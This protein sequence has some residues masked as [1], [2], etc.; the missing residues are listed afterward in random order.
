MTTHIKTVGYPT[1]KRINPK[2][3][4]AVFGASLILFPTLGSAD[5]SALSPDN[6]EINIIQADPLE[7]ATGAKSP[8]VDGLIEYSPLPLGEADIEAKILADQAMDEAVSLLSDSPPSLSTAPSA[9]AISIGKNFA[10]QTPANSAPPDTTGAIGPF[11]F[12]QL[13][14]TKAG[15]FNRTTGALV[16]SGTLNQLANIA[17]TVNSFDPQIIWDPTT[18][19]YYYVMDSIHSSTDARLSFGF[20]LTSNPSNVTTSWCHYQMTFGTRFPDYPKLGDSQYF[21]IIGANSFDLGTGGFVGSDIIAISKPGAGTTC[22]PA[23]TFKT[24]KKTVLR[25]TANNIVFTPVPANQIDTAATGYVVTRNGALPST[26]LWFFNVTKAGTGLPVFSNARG[27]TVA[28]YTLPSNA[29][30]PNFSASQAAPKL[31][32]LDARPTQAVQAFDPRFQTFSF[33]TQ[34]TI[35]NGAAGSAVRWYEI[36]PVP[37]V[38]VVKRQGNIGATNTYFFNAAVSPDRRVDGA[39]KAFGNNV[40][41]EY[42]VSSKANN[43]SPRIQASASPNG[44]AFSTIL[45]KAGVGPYRDF[46]CPTPDKVCRWGDYSGATPDPKPTTTTRGVVWGTNQFSGVVN[47]PANAV[48]W[49]TQI[50]SINP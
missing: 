29:T 9:P 36:D 39:T 41:V 11:S 24:G 32:T 2:M 23:S 33:W 44:A 13:V 3:G 22:P 49:R 7:P 19:R 21:M 45:V 12:I 40:V 4:L 27:V 20:S 18:N 8:T 15:I 30:Q 14:N 25:D 42:N 50:F 6:Q 37:A 38:P 47:P 17:S 43:V 28:S 35:Q 5:E 48:N 31:D 10:G 16:S 34:H 1:K 26:K 46:T